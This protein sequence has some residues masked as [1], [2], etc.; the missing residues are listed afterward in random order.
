MLVEAGQQPAHK[1]VVV[2]FGQARQQAVVGTQVAVG[3]NL[4]AAQHIAGHHANTRSLHPAVQQGIG[5]IKHLGLHDVL[6]TGTRY[7]AVVMRILGLGAGHGHHA[8][9]MVNTHVQPV[10]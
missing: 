1:V 8:L 9:G 2:A 7:H 6:H 5:R 10:A 4:L 3:S